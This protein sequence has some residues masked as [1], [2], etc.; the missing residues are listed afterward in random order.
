MLGNS[1]APTRLAARFAVVALLSIVF[2][3]CAKNV[4]QD[5][6][7]GEDAKYKGAKAIALENNEGEAKGIVTYPGGDRVDWRLIEIPEGKRGTL[8]I[9]LS[10]KPPRPGLDLAFDVYNEYGRKLGGVKAKK[11]SATKKSKKKKGSKKTTIQPVKGKVYVEVYASNRGDAGKYTLKVKF[12][13]EVVVVVP[14]FDPGSVEVPPPPKLAMVPPP[15]DPTAIDPKNPECKGV[16][17]PCDDKAPD[18]ANPN[19][20]GKSAPCDPALPDP[21]NPK[22]LPYFPDCDPLKIDKKNPKCAGV[23]PPKAQPVE[24]MIIQVEP[25]GTGVIIHINR[26]SKDQVD[27]KWTGE[28]VDGNGKPLTGGNFTIY[29]VQEKKSYAKVK[30]GKSVVDKNLDVMLYPP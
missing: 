11:P 27:T 29:K 18:P 22:C 3:G 12:A 25:T 14:V 9:E 2:A 28:I 21:L 23:T 17:P 1:P 7:S 19:C 15:C 26:G 16:H 20:A 8:E 10:W 30:L 4:K 13:E 24:A 5:S 6:H